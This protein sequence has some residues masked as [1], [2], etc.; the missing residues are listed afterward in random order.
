[1]SGVDLVGSMSELLNMDR[2]EYFR[3]IEQSEK[4]ARSID[5]AEEILKS[6]GITSTEEIKKENIK[7]NKRLRKL[8]D[9]ELLSS[10]EKG[11]YTMSSLGYM[12]VDSWRELNEKVMT[13]SKFREFFDTH[14]VENIPQEFLRQIYKLDKSCLT[15][16]PVDWMKELVEHT[17]KTKRK[18]YILTEQ[19]HSISEEII[20]KR[21]NNQIKEIVIIYQF[22]HYPSLN[23]LVKDEAS[24]FQKLVDAG[25]EFRYMTLSNTHPM[26][27]R[28]VDEGWATFGLARVSDGVLDRDN[29]FIGTD[30]DFI[31]WCRDL[32]YHIWHFRARKLE[33]SGI[34]AKEQKD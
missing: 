28:I 20:E 30:V 1:M 22:L 18:L 3:I 2:L 6:K 9:L 34:L 4:G 11:V 29:G 16:S 27:L 17:L 24:L 5:I 10:S 12:L 7:V 21:M 15:G 8:V 32:M 19:L 13:L 31:S 23:H 26:G 14:Y 25:A 33:T